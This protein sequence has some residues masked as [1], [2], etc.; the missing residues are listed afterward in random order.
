M[1][2]CV[3]DH[4]NGSSLCVLYNI[5]EDALIIDLVDDPSE[6]IDKSGWLWSDTAQI[7]VGEDIAFKCSHPAAD[8]IREDIEENPIW[9]ILEDLI[10]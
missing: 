9:D 1:K 4:S 5:L 2:G 7:T 3:L 6:M 10:S 8:Q